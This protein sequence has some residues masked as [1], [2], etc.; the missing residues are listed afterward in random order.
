M[1]LRTSETL[2][3]SGQD[4]N[5]HMQGM[6]IMM[7]QEATKALIDWPPINERIIKARFLL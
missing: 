7:M 5:Q 6:A 3:Y 2:L 1:Q 4:D